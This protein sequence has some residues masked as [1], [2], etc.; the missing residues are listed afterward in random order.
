MLLDVDSSR[1]ALSAPVENR[2]S[3]VPVENR[4]NVTPV[5]NRASGTLVANRARCGHVCVCVCMQRS[6][7]LLLELGSARLTPTHRLSGGEVK[8][9]A[10]WTRSC[11]LGSAPPSG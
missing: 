11:V 3:V 10:A 8:G 9:P 5:G 1:A 7:C 2:A 4:A 6:R